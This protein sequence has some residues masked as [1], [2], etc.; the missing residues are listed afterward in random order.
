[1]KCTFQLF[2]IIF[3]RKPGEFFFFFY[4]GGQSVNSTGNEV[5]KYKI[6][7]IFRWDMEYFFLTEENLRREIFFISSWDTR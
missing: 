7:S 5:E 6:S 2:K 4:L 3:L 1:M